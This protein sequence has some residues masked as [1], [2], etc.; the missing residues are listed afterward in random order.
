M[1]VRLRAA[2]QLAIPVGGKLHGLVHVVLILFWGKHQLNIRVDAT[3]PLVGVAPDH[4][5]TVYTG[6]G[7]SCLTYRT[8]QRELQLTAQ[9]Y[10]VGQHDCRPFLGTESS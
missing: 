7:G 9:P 5:L 2:G 6:R 1:A 8:G 3:I 4:L 10:S